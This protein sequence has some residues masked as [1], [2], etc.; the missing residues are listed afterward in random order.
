MLVNCIYCGEPIDTDRRDY[1]NLPGPRGIISAHRWCYPPHQVDARPG[2]T[3]LI[4][5]DG[6]VMPLPDARGRE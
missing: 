5:K 6:N 1:W 4:D 3:T 2:E